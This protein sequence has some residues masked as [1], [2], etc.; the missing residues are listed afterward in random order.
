MERLIMTEERAIRIYQILIDYGGAPVSD[1]ES[2]VGSMT[3]K[4]VTLW[5]I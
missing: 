1:I 3:K 2:F 4:L 5:I